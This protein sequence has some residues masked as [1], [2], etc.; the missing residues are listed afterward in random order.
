[1]FFS[2]F[3]WFA[4][5]FAL[6]S[7]AFYL[8]SAYHFKLNYLIYDPVYMPDYVTK[9][10]QYNPWLFD[11]YTFDASFYTLLAACILYSLALVSA[12]TISCRI[13]MS[14]AWRRRYA[15]SYE[16]LEM[17]DLMASSGSTAGAGY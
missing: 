9:A 17:H 15:D 16:V 1:M 5:L 13:Q 2:I 14:P 6:A 10:Y 4:A 3:V 11:V 12:V 8:I 7:L